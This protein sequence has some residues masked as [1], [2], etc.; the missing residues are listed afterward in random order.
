MKLKFHNYNFDNL[1]ESGDE[2]HAATGLTV[3]SFN[4]FLEFLN[5]GRGSCNITFYDTSSKLSQSCNDIGSAK[6]GPRPKLSSQDQLFMYMTWLKNGF[7]VFLL[8]ISVCNPNLAFK[9]S[10]RQH[11]DT[12]F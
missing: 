3:E 5:P 2:F 6:S 12:K 4:D 8:F 11:H 9:R 1:S 10:N 7:D